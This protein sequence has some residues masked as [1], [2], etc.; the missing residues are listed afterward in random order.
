MGPGE[1]AGF[2]EF[3]IF[4]SEIDQKSWGEP[5]AL[6]PS[7]EDYGRRMRPVPLY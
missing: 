7:A 2:V 1:C 6:A 4:H 3:W 5:T